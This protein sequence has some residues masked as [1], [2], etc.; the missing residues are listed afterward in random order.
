MS[1]YNPTFG[2]ENYTGM[3][4]HSAWSYK[5][6]LQK[7]RKHQKRQGHRTDHLEQLVMIILARLER[8]ESRVFYSDP[9]DGF[10]PH[11]QHT[12]YRTFPVDELLGKKKKKAW[13]EFW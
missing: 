11:S 9:F 13:R 5:A 10:S 1:N 7:V 3:D 2:E 12:Y 4:S 6:V 8:L